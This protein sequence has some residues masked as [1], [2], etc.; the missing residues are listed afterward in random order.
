MGMAGVLATQ[1][2]GEHSQGKPLA[3]G[4]R[5]RQLPEQT[6]A[7]VDRLVKLQLRLLDRL[8]LKPQRDAPPRGELGSLRL[9][10]SPAMA[11]IT[12]SW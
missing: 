8:V 9:Q 2:L 5:E 6:S 12:A 1:R 4:K 7:E 11:S 10:M 3:D